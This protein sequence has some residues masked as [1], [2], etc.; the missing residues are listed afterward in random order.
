MFDA[1]QPNARLDALMDEILRVRAEARVAG[2]FRMKP[3]ERLD[4]HVRLADAMEAYAGCRC[5]CR[6]ADRRIVRQGDEASPVQGTACPQMCPVISRTG[7]S[8]PTRRPVRLTMP[9]SDRLCALTERSRRSRV[10][11]ATSSN[12]AHRVHSAKRVSRVLRLVLLPRGPLEH[13]PV[14]PHVRRLA[15]CRREAKARCASTSRGSPRS[16]RSM[17][18][19]A[20]AMAASCANSKSMRRS[21]RIAPRALQASRAA[22]TV[23]NTPSMSRTSRTRFSVPVPK[24]PATPDTPL[25][26]PPVM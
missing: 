16:S 7:P 2:E 9:R 14:Y 12:T 21:R 25:L 18:A 4:F 13:V 10:A 20:A 11:L 23:A 8:R 1:T 24:G 26:S 17:W 3:S 6:C 22:A 19:I 15:M 5:D